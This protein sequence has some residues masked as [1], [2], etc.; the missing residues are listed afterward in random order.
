LR[1]LV[2]GAGL[3]ALLSVPARAASTRTQTGG[4]LL[5]NGGAEAGPGATGD[6][7][8]VAPPG[9]TTSGSFTAARYG[10]QGLPAAGSGANLFAGG[11]GSTVSTAVQTVS[12]SADAVAIDSGQRRATLSASLGGWADQDDFATVEALFLDDGGSSLGSLAIG[13]VTEPDR[14]GQTVL[15]PR[16]SKKL[17]PAGTRSI[18][19]V[20]TAERE[21][22]SYNDGYIDDVALVL[23]AAQPA[24]A[25]YRFGFRIFDR[26]SDLSAGSSGSFTTQGQPDSSGMSKV[27]SV[28]AKNLRL[29][30]RYQGKRW[31]VVFA[32][33]AGGLYSSESRAVVLRLAVRTSNVP[34]CRAGGSGSISINQ[35]EDVTLRFCGRTI[36]FL[37]PDRASAW[38]KPA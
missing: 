36:K 26:T 35:S 2:L 4:N 14:N 1:L 18:R 34:N 37:A 22:G 16:S 23:A 20:I 12:V 8:V 25:K 32:F 17:V 28:S 29:G 33:R 31:L 21:Q 15:L 5:Q 19:V 10:T 11:P 9:W 38:I 30:W 27:T 3:I 13:P 6:S 7:Q 24:Q